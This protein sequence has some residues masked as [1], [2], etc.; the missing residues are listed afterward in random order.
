MADRNQFHSRR[1]DSTAGV[2]AATVVAGTAY[3]ADPRPDNHVIRLA[4]VAVVAVHCGE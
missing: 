3:C 2:A 1:D 4:D